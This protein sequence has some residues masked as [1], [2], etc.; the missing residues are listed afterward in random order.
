M[1]LLEAMQA[2]LN[3]ERV[4][5]KHWDERRYIVLDADSKRLV[6]EEGRFTNILHPVAGAGAMEGVLA[7][8]WEIYNAGNTLTFRGK[9]LDIVKY[10]GCHHCGNCLISPMCEFAKERDLFMGDFLI[11]TDNY[12][13][14]DEKKI[15]AMY[16]LINC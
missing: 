3:G 14:L 16:N 2:V 6:D 9:V 7:E 12:N 10:C 1:N 11:S 13:D 4:R 5:R 8:E 15:D